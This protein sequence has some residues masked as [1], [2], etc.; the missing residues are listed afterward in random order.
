MFLLIT[1]LL[2]FLAPLAFFLLALFVRI[3]AA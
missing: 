1:L 2:F 3:L